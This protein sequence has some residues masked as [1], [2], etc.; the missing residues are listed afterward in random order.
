MLKM[1]HTMLCA[2][3][4]ELAYKPEDIDIVLFRFLPF[5][6]NVLLGKYERK[7]TFLRAAMCHFHVHSRRLTV[8][9]TSM[10]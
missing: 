5:V 2:I 9:I 4:P 8:G 3:V 7:K 6:R 10:S 1:D